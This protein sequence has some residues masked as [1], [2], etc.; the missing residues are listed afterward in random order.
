MTRFK[1]AFGL[2]AEPTGSASGRL[3]GRLIWLGCL[4]CFALARLSWSCL[5]S[6]PH[7]GIHKGG[8]AAEGR[9]PPFVEA[10]RSAASLMRLAGK[11]RP[12]QPSQGKAS[13]AAERNQP[14]Q[15]SA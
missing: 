14:A 15:K 13:Q 5:A 11:A 8:A 2:R 10:A 12:T 1:S 4:A 9:R 7:K 6:K 3:L